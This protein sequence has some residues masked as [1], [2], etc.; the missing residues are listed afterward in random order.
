M[1]REN[2]GERVTGRQ[3]GVWSVWRWNEEDWRVAKVKKSE[4]I[5]L[6]K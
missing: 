1:E 3:R 6:Q 4:K 5:H 2:D